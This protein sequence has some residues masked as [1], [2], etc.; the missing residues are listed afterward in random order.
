MRI[1]GGAVFGLTL[2]IPLGIATG[3]SQAQQQDN[4]LLGQAQRLLNGNGNQNSNAYEQGRIDQQGRRQAERERRHEERAYN[5]G[6][7][8][9]YDNDGA[10]LRATIKARIVGASTAQPTAVIQTGH[11][12][13]P[14]HLLADLPRCFCVGATASAAP[15]RGAAASGANS[16]M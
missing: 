13:G 15:G 5:R 16:L 8:Q 6:P 7:Q 2:A 3:G 11:I 1:F 14:D 10:Y 4:G 9:G 12:A